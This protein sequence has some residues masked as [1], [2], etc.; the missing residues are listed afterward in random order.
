VDRHEVRRAEN[1]STKSKST[2]QTLD[3]SI[4]SD[5]PMIRAMNGYA[6]NAVTRR[7]TAARIFE[8]SMRVAAGFPDQPERVHLLAGSAREAPPIF[9]E[10]EAFDLVV[11]G[12]VG[13]DGLAGEILGETAEWILRAVRCSVLCV[14]PRHAGA[15]HAARSTLHGSGAHPAP[16]R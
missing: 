16:R 7:Q 2:A 3:L 5:T 14:S 9:I 11:R 6:E 15:E 1:E 12:T 8:W 10:D 13:R 4:A